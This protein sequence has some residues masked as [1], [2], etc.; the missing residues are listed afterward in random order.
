MSAGAWTDLERDIASQCWRSASGI[1]VWRDSEV[2]V[3][4]KILEHR[5]RALKHHRI[6]REEQ[7]T[8]GRAIKFI[9]GGTVWHEPS[10]FSASRHPNPS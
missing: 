1:A 9:P 3:V 5:Y 7:N 2:E 8:S 10:I 4:L 6:Y